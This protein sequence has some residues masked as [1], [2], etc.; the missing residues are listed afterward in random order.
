[1]TVTPDA[2]RNMTAAEKRAL[3]AELMR[4][5]SQQ[6]RELPLS[7]AQQRLWFL[8]RLQAGGSL[9][10]IPAAVR[11]QMPLQV[12]PLQRAINEVVRRHEA[13][14][15]VFRDRGD[16]PR[17]V[18]VPE[19]AIEVP[20]VDLT[21]LPE[22]ARDME[23]QRLAAKEGQRG[24][25]LTTGPL[26]RATLVR[27][28][29]ADHVLLLTM[30]HIVSD[31]WSMQVLLRE[32]AELYEAFASGRTPSLP[33]LPMQ[34]GDFAV[35]Q[36]EWLSGTRYASLLSYW[37]S[38]LDG[39]PFVLDL[40]ADHPRPAVQSFRGAMQAF[41]VSATV[42]SAL[43]T[44]S[45]REGVTMF[46]TC[47]AAFATL[48]HRITGQRDLVIG[49][50]IA[51][52][53]RA[54]LE[55]LIGF[56]VNTLVLRS[57]ADGNPTFRELLTAI[58]ET[59]LGAYANQDLPF[60]KLVEEL[61]PE[62]S[63]SHNPLFQVA[64]TLQTVHA[65]ATTMA[66]ADDAGDLP[67]ENPPPVMA[68]TA[69]FDLSLTL[70]EMPRGLAGAFEYT[71]DL[72]NASTIQRFAE[73]FQT[74]L[75]AIAA[76]PDQ[77]LWHLPVLPQAQRQQ[78]EQWNE[79]SA[80]YPPSCIHEIFEEA[81]ARNPDGV[82]V[83][84]DDTSVT[85][86]E[87]DARANQLAHFL[88]RQG[89]GPESLAAICIER[90]VEMMVAVLGVL[91]AGG[92]YVPLD[93]DYPRGRIE[94]LVQ[95]AQPAVL[96]TLEHLTERFD[97]TAA[98]CLDR[99]WPEIAREKTTK[100]N[101][102]VSL[103]NLA[104]VIYTSG[105]TGTPKGAMVPH[106]G[107]AN[108]VAMQRR[109]FRLTPSDRVLQFVSLSFDISVFDFLNAFG[110]AAT[111]VLGT[112]DTLAPG[113]PLARTIQERGVTMM[114]L[115]PSVFATLTAHDF[116][117]VHTMVSGGEVCTAEIV[118][119]F[120]Q[121]RHFVNGYGPT[122]TSIVV[123]FAECS[124]G[125]K[126]PSI[127]RAFPNTRLYVLDPQMEPVPVGVP[128]EL[129]IGGVVVD[130]GYLRRPDLTAERF[131]ADPFTSDAG[132]RMYKTGDLVRFREDGEVDFLGRLDEQVK[133]RG[134]RIELGEIEAVLREH[135]AVV[136]AAVVVTE[137]LGDRRLAAFVV[138]S[139]EPPSAAELRQF[140]HEL[141]PEYMVPSTFGV[142]DAM[143]AMPSGK[144]DRKA[145]AALTSPAGSDA[146]YVAPRTEN[147][148]L[149]AAIW[150]EVLGLEGVGIHDNFFELGGHS[151]SATQVI[152]RVR[153]SLNVEVPLRAL[154]ELP[155][156]A[157]F[158]ASFDAAAAEAVASENPAAAA[159][160][161]DR[162]APVSFAQRR[163]WFLDRMQP[164][165]P[166]Y[167]IPAALELN[168]PLQVPA[169]QRSLDELARRHDALRTTFRLGEDDQPV[170]HVA[171]G[172]SLNLEVIDLQPLPEAARRDEAA[173]IAARESQYQFDLEHGPLVRAL[174][175]R[176]SDTEHV[177]LL[178]MHH[179]ISDG[180]SMRIL[181]SELEQLYD[182]ASSGRAHAL[183]PLPMQYADF[184]VWQKEWL[185]G[186]R[187]DGLLSYWRR[188]MEGAPAVLAL[189]TDRPRRA[190]Q[191]FRGAAH[192]FTIPAA[193]TRALKA[194]GQREGA[195]LFM[196]LAAAFVALLHRASGE[197]DIV[198][199]IP[200][201]NR[202]RAAVE[203]VVGFFVN[204]LVLRTRLSG[205]PTFAELLCRVRETTLTAYEH[206]DLPFEK[207]V[208]ELQPERSLSHNP[209]FQVM[210]MFQSMLDASI[211]DGVARGDV[212]MSNGTAK[213]DLTLSLL[214][215][216]QGLF[217]G[218]EYSVDLFDAPTIATLAQQF[219]DLAALVASDPSL[220]LS[221]LAGHQEARR[222][223]HTNA[224]EH[225]QQQARRQRLD[226]ARRVTV[227]L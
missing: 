107:L 34:Y 36:R 116:P 172:G 171:A 183:P 207:L 69:K 223:E 61:Q 150:S 91:K 48:L 139:G 219:T 187:L 118:R 100:P 50:P 184:A 32:L 174:L 195:T 112:R 43:K 13:L 117:N 25:D 78:L 197:E 123:T 3:L 18:I 227:D 165:T 189:P 185:A 153:A 193:A 114:T 224:R 136:D 53:N 75:E 81:A 108:L 98:I 96:L 180:W 225:T 44:L 110:A 182:A 217:G 63:L 5:K 105:S 127:G 113:E 22:K 188:T 166:L 201:A 175:L 68:G 214:E 151:L 160:P 31:A 27:L 41:A 60:E 131:L 104:Y 162:V 47:F 9:Y 80:E 149:V 203:R 124:D 111:L 82:A 87:L 169:L 206:Q 15:T 122:E 88:R 205:D 1:M 120:A 2:V 90:S 11:L 163:L 101:V 84:L 204:T 24:F 70:G 202:N 23:A 55:G 58:R 140:V 106:R 190:V 57:R 49:T 4:K 137:V 38:A 86:R 146:D 177:L 159:S 30:H 12:P 213:F 161:R 89:V 56:F 218:F 138:A 83:L 125:A 152:S 92:A 173:R 66:I 6:P 145:L 93:P 62:R 103:D 155:D 130:R 208:E 19:L 42:T 14:R 200:I 222:G 156:L 134:Y 192:N 133:L 115:L 72:F 158:A 79:T 8:D 20:L 95:D 97:M 198:V 141:L 129:Y 209:L 148:R 10:N 186:E 154:F 212:E 132:G 39:A 194:V 226:T 17:Q 35:A 126:K 46:M 128:G 59:T 178:T 109:T 164:G 181:I 199:G 26:F 167:N 196:T 121:G 215:T 67:A 54:E 40:P 142:L 21:A 170:Q 7:F 64:F 85:Y 28:S 119:H 94:H 176:F 147:E 45:Q 99:Q 16:G 52:R 211:A 73:N 191:T 135:P 74:L 210:F 76:D 29:T 71:T 77:P 33:T 220:R 37:K 216:E 143:P 102:A 179:I 65:E 144:V 51:N 168:I 221:E 157:T